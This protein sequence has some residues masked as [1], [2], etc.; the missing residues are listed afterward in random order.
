[1]YVK[2]TNSETVTNEYTHTQI[3]STAFG[4]SG[5]SWV[6]DNGVYTIMGSGKL[7][8]PG[9]DGYSIS[10]VASDSCD[11][12]Y[13]EETGDFDIYVK[14]DQIPK[15]ENFVVAGLMVRETLDT[16]SRM[17]FL[18]DGWLKYGENCEIIHRDNA[19]ATSTVTYFNNSDRDAIQN[20]DSYDTSDEAYSMPSYMRIQRS[21]DTLTFS[22]SDS[23]YGDEWTDNARQPMSITFDS[24]ASTL[25]VGLAV[26]SAQGTPMKEYMSEAKFEIDPEIVVAETVTV[27]ESTTWSFGEE[28]FT[29]TDEDGT[30]HPDTEYFTQDGSNYTVSTDSMSSDNAKHF[31]G[32]TY[33]AG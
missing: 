32:L 9:G 7:V 13:K 30:T 22:V 28:P 12:M 11:F 4:T 16:G 24:L 1:M 14:M 26:D 10:G 15:Y 6:D 3:G 21:G 17:A 2:G 23:G 33:T 25:Y 5:G 18:A 19:D 29:V 31:N 27:D 8:A 20:G